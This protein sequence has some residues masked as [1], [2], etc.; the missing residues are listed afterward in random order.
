[1]AGCLFLQWRRLLAADVLGIGDS[2]DE[3]G[4][5]LAGRRLRQVPVAA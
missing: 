1:M 4:S 2:G 5:R 3:T